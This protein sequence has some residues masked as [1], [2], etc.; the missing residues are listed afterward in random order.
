MERETTLDRFICLELN[1]IRS[2][3]ASIGKI[4]A[5]EPND[6]LRLL[7]VQVSVTG[8]LTPSGHARAQ[9]GLKL[10]ANL[11]NCGQDNTA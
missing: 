11:P 8:T 2:L 3:L 4:T 5:P 1:N 6:C 9:W 7:T 10:D